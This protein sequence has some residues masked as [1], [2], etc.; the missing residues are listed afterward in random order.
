MNANRI[1]AP[2]LVLVIA[3]AP[4]SA[5]VIQQQY[6]I[7]PGGVFQYFPSPEG[8][9]IPGGMPSD[10][11]LDFGIGGTFVYELDTA[12]EPARLLNLDLVLTGNEA[13]QPT[14]PPAARVTADHVEA[15]LASHAFVTDFIGGLLH[16][17]SST[18]PDLKLTDSLNG[19]LLIAGGYDA[20]PVD[21]DGLNFRFSARA[22]PEPATLALLAAAALAIACRRTAA[23][24]RCCSMAPRPHKLML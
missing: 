16:L 12:G 9:G 8:P 15:Y 17:E 13:I 24:A 7:N 23:A 10:Y 3:V 4:V 1:W 5:A 2:V 18:H 22:I 14:A 20:R 21:G 19:H 11:Q 6:Q